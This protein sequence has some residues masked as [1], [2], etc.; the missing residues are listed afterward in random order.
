M[1]T[2]PT[3]TTSVCSLC[4]S[5]GG[6]LITDGNTAATFCPSA[7]IRRSLPGRLS[8]GLKPDGVLPFQKSKEDAKAAFLK[9]CRASRCFPR[10]S[11]ARA[12]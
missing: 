1:K 12:S 4:S 10:T 6:E 11:R 7:A 2:G 8:G 5:C 9:L 3:R